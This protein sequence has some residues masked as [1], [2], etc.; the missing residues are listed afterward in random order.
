MGT[1][2]KIYWWETFLWVGV[3]WFWS[4]VIFKEVLKLNFFKFWISLKILRPPAHPTIFFFTFFGFHCS[5]PDN[6]KS[7]IFMLCSCK[8]FCDIFLTQNEKFRIKEEKEFRNEMEKSK[9]E[10][11][12]I[13]IKLNI[14]WFS[15]DLIIWVGVRTTK[16][17]QDFQNCFFTKIN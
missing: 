6:E 14:L 2:I 4:I 8:K 11:N 13:I 12:P 1:L 10:R 17:Y 9:R 16:L 5:Y 3:T 7:F 15:V